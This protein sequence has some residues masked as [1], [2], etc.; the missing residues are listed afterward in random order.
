M[1]RSLT[2]HGLRGCLLRGTCIFMLVTIGDS[3]CTNSKDGPCKGSPIIFQN[4][5]TGKNGRAL[6]IRVLDAC[7]AS[8]GA[9]IFGGAKVQIWVRPSV[10]SP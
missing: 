1:S 7:S 4:G 5:R 3:V 8:P 10:T 6:H 9:D 2:P